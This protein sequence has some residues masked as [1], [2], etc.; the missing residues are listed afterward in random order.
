MANCGNHTDPLPSCFS[1]VTT[2]ACDS[3]P[4]VPVSVGHAVPGK[5]LP[6]R[7]AAPAIRPARAG[8]PA[9][10][11]PLQCGPPGAS[12]ESRLRHRP[13]HHPGH[14]PG[15]GP[16]GS[17]VELVRRP[18]SE[19][20]SFFDL[21]LPR[22]VGSGP[23]EGLQ[24]GANWVRRYRGSESTGLAANVSAPGPASASDL[25]VSDHFILGGG[26]FGQCKWSAA[27]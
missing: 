27:V 26:Q 10:W 20:K 19:Q 15:H 24:G 5:N 8:P 14:R 18:R 7:S 6:L 13:G 17:T 9:D 22:R 21:R 16:G 25:P 2:Y 23:G 11:S 3:E 4:A 12:L 1:P